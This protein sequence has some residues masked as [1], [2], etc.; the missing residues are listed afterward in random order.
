MSRLLRYV[1]GWVDRRTGRP[2]YRFRRR[3]FPSV[4]LPGVPGSAEFMG[5]YQAA[6]ANTPVPIGAKRNAPGS[7]AYVVAAYLDSQSHFGCLAPGTRTIRRATL[8]RFREAHGGLPFATMPPKFIAWLL[9]K[10]KPHVARS[11]LKALRGLCRFAI[12]L[13]FPRRRSNA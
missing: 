3:G 6:M 10:K 7:V 8:D 1:Q 12:A 2:R 11:W 4:E 13:G 9:D 5:A